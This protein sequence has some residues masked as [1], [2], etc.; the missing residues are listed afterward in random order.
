MMGPVMDAVGPRLRRSRLALLVALGVDNFGSGLFLP[1][2]LV[3]ATRVIG[4]PLWAAGV[5]VSVSSLFGLLIP[6]L[7]GPLVDRIGPRAVVIA[8]QLM[9]AGGTAAYFLADGVP[10]MA[11]GAVLL[12]GGQRTFYSGLFSL[13]ADVAEE[14]PKDHSFAVVSMVRSAAFG[15]GSLTTGILLTTVSDTGLRVAVGVNTTTLVLAAVMLTLLVRPRVHAARPASRD[16]GARLGVLRN[17]PFVALIVVTSMFALT[18]QFFLVGAPVY[19]LEELHTPGWVPGASLALLTGLFALGGTVAVRLTKGLKRTTS[20]AVA[21][22]MSIAWSL[23]SL[24]ALLLPSAWQAPWLVACTLFLAAAGLIN[25]TRANALAEAAAPKAV[26]GRYLAAFQY[27]FA[28]PELVAPLVVSLFV[29]G[30]WVPWLVLVAVACLG[31]LA[32][33]YL[34]RQLPAHALFA[35]TPSDLDETAGVDGRLESA[36]SGR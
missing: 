25:G 16:G 21:G 14:G 1:L 34:S 15:L 31:L 6:P 20:M 2:S 17:P 7:A 33:P 9:Q 19:A 32:V 36:E 13:I 5:V 11:L 10:G 27:A 23:A 26:R 3:Y 30:T 29:V 35:E 24:A 28:I 4:V 18:G 12:G 22:G 8:S